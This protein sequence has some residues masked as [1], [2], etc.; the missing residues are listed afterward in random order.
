MPSVN[1]LNK[2]FDEDFIIKLPGKSKDEMG[3]VLVENGNYQGFVDVF[4]LIETAIVGLISKRIIFDR[5]E[6]GCL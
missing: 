3:V 4:E 2:I 5:G 1:L 6:Y